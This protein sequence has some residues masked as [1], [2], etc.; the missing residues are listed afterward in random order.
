MSL[1][2]I[3]FK[4]DIKNKKNNENIKT[5]NKNFLRLEDINL[6]DNYYKNYKYILIKDSSLKKRNDFSLQNFID[7]FLENHEDI[8]IFILSSYKEN[9]QNLNKIDN[10][11]DYN[12]YQSRMPG[13]IGSFIFNSEKWPVIKNYLKDSGEEKITKA[14]KNLAYDDKLKMAFSW[15]QIYYNLDNNNMLKICRE[16]SIG[17]IDPK[18][19]EIS[20]YWFFVNLI[21]S[22]IFIYLIYD[23]IPKNKYYFLDKK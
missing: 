1:F 5:V 15:P 18:I 10:Y 14:L 19:K 17:I 8:D 2:T 21:F 3:D 7:D 9:C 23:K 11:F 22:V 4:K 6:L 13:E 20:Y 16:E 12:F